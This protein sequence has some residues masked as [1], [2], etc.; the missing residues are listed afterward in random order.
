MDIETNMYE[1][2]CPRKLARDL[3]YIMAGIDCCYIQYRK[4]SGAAGEK[5]VYYATATAQEQLE[6][7]VANSFYLAGNVQFAPFNQPQEAPAE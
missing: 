2:S 3:L 7:V 5:I 4:D 6:F 1:A